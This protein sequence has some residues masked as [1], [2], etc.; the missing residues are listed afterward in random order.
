MRTF[1]TPHKVSKLL[2]K[3]FGS[4]LTMA[5]VHTVTS[6]KLSLFTCLFFYILNNLAS[7]VFVVKATR[8]RIFH[9]PN[10]QFKKSTSTQMFDMI[11]KIVTVVLKAVLI[12]PSILPS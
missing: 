3:C 10:H 2:K 8:I 5:N 11:F 9:Q 4:P 7:T 6:S 1:N 12:L